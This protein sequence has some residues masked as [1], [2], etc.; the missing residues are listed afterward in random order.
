MISSLKASLDDNRRGYKL[1]KI[2]RI[3]FIAAIGLLIA[4][5][6]LSSPGPNAVVSQRL[7]QTA[8]VI[9]ALVVAL[10]LIELLHLR[11]QRYRIAPD[12]SFV[13]FHGTIFGCR[14]TNSFSTLN[15]VSGASPC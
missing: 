3:A 12:G 11:S 8:Y 10:A 6:A 14:A 7:A 4:S 15:L 5:G 1:L 9:F 13:S 2:L